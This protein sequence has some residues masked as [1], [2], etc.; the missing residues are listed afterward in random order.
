MENTSL[1]N[2]FPQ[3]ILVRTLHYCD[4]V[5]I[6]RFS[7]T[8]KK[9]QRVVSCSVSLQLHIEL[10][11]NG[12]EIADGSSGGNP[13]YSLA[14]KE[15]RDHQ[16]A[17]YNLR[18]GPMVQQSVGASDIDVPD[19]DLRNGTYHGEFR[20]SE[21]DDDDD[22]HVDHTQIAV[23]GSST[24][25]PPTNFEKEFSSC[26]VDPTQDLAVLVEDEQEVYVT[27]IR[28]SLTCKKAYEIV[29][30]SVSLQLHIELEI[31]G[32]EIANG[33]SK[34]S[35]NYSSTL[36][37]LK[38][39]QNAWFNM[40]FS[41]MIQQ[42][43]GDPKV[44][45]PNWDLRS[46]TYFGD[47]RVSELE[48]EED[49]LVDHTQIAVL[50]SSNLPP[51]INFGKKFNHNAVDPNQDLVILVEDEIEGSE[52]ARFHLRSGT[53]GQAH[54]L[55]EYPVLTVSFDST[56]LRKNNL[57]DASVG[58]WPEIM[59]NYFTVKIYWPETSCE[60][61]EIL[62]WDWKTGILLSRIYLEH[63]SARCTFLD[64]ERLLVYSVLPE[65]D[66]QSTRIA[67]LVYRIPIATIDHEVPPDANSCV[68][69]YPKHDPI[70]IF[71]LPELHPSWEVTGQHFML[72]SEPLPGD[73]VYTKSATLLCSHVTTFCLGFRIWNNPRRQRYVYGSRKGTP[74]DFHVLVSVHHLLPYLLGRQ[75]DGVTTR[76]IPWSQWGTVATR[77]FIEDHSI[78]HLTDRIYRSQYIRS[79]TTKSG[80]AQLISIVD[81][82]APLIK[83]YQYTAT[84]TS[85]AKRA[86]ADK[87]EKNAV[88]EGNGM[89]E[90]RLFQTR[91]GSTRLPVPTI[92][93]ALNHEVLTETIGSDMKTIIRAGF[94][95]PVVSCL[96]YRVVTKVQLMPTHG[97]WRIHGE[98][99]VGI[100]RRD[101]SENIPFS[102]YKLELSSQE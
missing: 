78:E 56:F 100:P 2:V 41:P 73:V 97:H 91:I 46:G 34:G 49:F 80:Q 62:L 53:T 3:E 44:E 26:V 43:I 21:P 95:D 51:P 31:N 32:L 98:Y 48:H 94:K 22:F 92:G 74:T 64:K 7:L 58:A 77:W 88:L 42:P 24:I 54:P 25:P 17:W 16:D 9:A 75:S 27:I 82:N 36:K 45:V 86:S 96:P 40:K 39:Y 83:R 11:I 15:L 69:L 84:A 38:E 67:L 101:W 71:E 5:T 72:G 10:E 37:E 6:I 52:F 1:I 30:F 57:L 59:G 4:Y 66:T 68:P 102:L 23:L 20:A 12:L 8:C 87:S 19:W 63:R 14:L 90:G 70:L 99:L 47:F 60:I 61:S 50:G 18:L 35:I 13:N 81:F 33:S 28:F 55:A 79:T 65:N 85:R 29:S 93:K 89:T 76:I